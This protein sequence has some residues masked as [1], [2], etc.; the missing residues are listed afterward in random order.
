MAMRPASLSRVKRDVMLST[1]RLG[2]NG[3]GFCGTL[4]TG[5]RGAVGVLVR[6]GGGGGADSLVRQVGG[7]VAE[8]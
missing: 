3:A 2:L 1:V 4:G 7:E 6:Q 5:G 8:W